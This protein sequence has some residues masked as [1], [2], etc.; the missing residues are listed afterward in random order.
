MPGP[1]STWKRG[2]RK[3]YWLEEPKK[4][5]KHLRRLKLMQAVRL[6]GYEAVKG[7]QASG[8]RKPG[9]QNLRKR[10]WHKPYA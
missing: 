3:P 10:G 7:K 5:T 1:N 9:S 4:E 8:F 6:A 2:H